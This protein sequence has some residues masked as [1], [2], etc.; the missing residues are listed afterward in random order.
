MV[1]DENDEHFGPVG[2]KIVVLEPLEDLLSH[3]LNLV[4]TL[5][6]DEAQADH[7]VNALVLLLGLHLQRG[8]AAHQ[9]IGILRIDDVTRRASSQIVVGQLAIAEV[10][11]VVA[12]VEV[13][14]VALLQVELLVLQQVV[15]SSLL[16]LELTILILLLLVQSTMIE[17]EILI[18]LF[19]VSFKDLV[20]LHHRRLVIIYL[21]FGASILSIAS[22][23]SVVG[24]FT[25]RLEHD[26]LECFVRSLSSVFPDELFVVVSVIAFALGTLC[27]GTLHS[28]IT[29]FTTEKISKLLRY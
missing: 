28:L 23:L 10:A 19:L 26:I 5:I 2:V 15:D 3:L 12:L 24:R 1:G 7:R 20:R 9:W 25:P 16:R 27:V 22:I 8:P 4:Q 21:A 17:L 18:Y 14:R 29:H 6:A 13:E 11:L